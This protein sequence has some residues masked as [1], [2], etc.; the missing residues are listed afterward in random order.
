MKPHHELSILVNRHVMTLE[1]LEDR[2]TFLAVFTDHQGKR[3]VA[4][5]AKK[6]EEKQCRHKRTIVTLPKKEF[7]LESTGLKMV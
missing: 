3:T 6:A 5:F 7:L 1:I 2:H 4:Q